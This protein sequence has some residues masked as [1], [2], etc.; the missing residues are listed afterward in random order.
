MNGVTCVRIRDVREFNEI[1]EFKEG[2]NPIPKLLKLFYLLNL[3]LLRVAL[4][5][6]AAL[7]RVHDEAQEVALYYGLDV[8]LAA[9]HNTY[10]VAL[11]LVECAVAH[12]ARKHK[13]YAHL[14]HH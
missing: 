8:A 12:V 6:V 11:K 5:V 2:D 9:T 1:K 13:L 4:V 10:V 3:S 14:L 7:A